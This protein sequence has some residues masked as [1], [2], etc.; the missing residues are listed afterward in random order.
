MSETA[1][2]PAAPVPAKKPVWLWILLGCGG[3][4]LVAAVAVGALLYAAISTSRV[5]ATRAQ[6]KGNLRQVGIA[7]QVYAMDKNKFPPD[8]EA[9]MPKYVDDPRVLQ[10]P[11]RGGAKYVYL[12][13]RT[14]TMPANT[15]LAYEP[16]GNHGG[17]GFN[18][19]FVDAHVES[20]AN[21]RRA[22]LET[23]VAKQEA[24]IKKA[25]K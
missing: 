18:V 10:C 24:D 20:W 8:L 5:M 4:F 11:A 7:C 17:R 12:P 6:C 25:K 15:V 21:D 22:E 14:P 3:L 19:L 1:T 16:A 2:A 23:T 9:L 13:G